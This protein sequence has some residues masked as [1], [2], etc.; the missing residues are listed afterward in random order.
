MG[1]AVEPAER[2][3]DL[4]DRVDQVKAELVPGELANF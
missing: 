4:L 1:K 3:Q 2:E